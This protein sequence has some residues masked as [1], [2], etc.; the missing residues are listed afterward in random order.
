MRNSKAVNLLSFP[1]LTFAVELFLEQ[2]KLDYET[3]LK[4][5]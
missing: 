4:Q 5:V 1:C 3:S 2:L